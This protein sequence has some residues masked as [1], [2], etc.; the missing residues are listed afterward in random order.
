MMRVKFA[1]MHTPTFR[2]TVPGASIIQAQA[3]LNSTRCS[4]LR[5][6]EAV[7]RRIRL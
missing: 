5:L 2:Q 7:L 1:H 6:V 3:L 4:S